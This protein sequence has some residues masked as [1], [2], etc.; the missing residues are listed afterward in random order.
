MPEKGPPLPGYVSTELYGLE[1]FKAPV[2]DY[3]RGVVNE[4][5]RKLD[6]FVK[7]GN[8]IVVEPLDETGWASD[9]IA[10]NGVLS[11]SPTGTEWTV[12]LWVHFE[13]RKPEDIEGIS[14]G[15]LSHR[16]PGGEWSPEPEETIEE[17]SYNLTA[18]EGIKA[19]SQVQEH[20]GKEQV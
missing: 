9:S 16:K 15:F 1:A 17:M 12:E 10:Y 13:W 2:S 3:G 6:D 18:D 20:L 14:I 7:A 5:A 11:H 8:F 19:S 4:A